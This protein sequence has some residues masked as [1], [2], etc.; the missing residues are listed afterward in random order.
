MVN[1]IKSGWNDLKDRWLCYRHGVCYRHREELCGYYVLY[2]RS[3]H[4]EQIR[5]KN[6]ERDSVLDR[7]GVKKEDKKYDWK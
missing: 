4:E 1:I 6:I 3:C 5:R 7:L 2:C